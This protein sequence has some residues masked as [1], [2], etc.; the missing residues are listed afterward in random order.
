MTTITSNC[1]G[2]RAVFN[3]GRQYTADGQIIAWEIIGHQHDE[4]D[5]Y[6]LFSD[7]FVVSFVDYSR[8]IDGTVR[9]CVLDEDRLP[10]NAEI[11]RSY[12]RG[13]YGYDDDRQRVH[14]LQQMAHFARKPE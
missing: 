8:G 6:G 10:T 7:L 13:D 2:H 3:T 4:D 14:K 1:I 11:L 12:D 5:D 9:V